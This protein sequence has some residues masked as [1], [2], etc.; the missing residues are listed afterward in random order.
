M[1]VLALLVS[2]SHTTRATE[3]SLSESDSELESLS[4][5]L[6]GSASQPE[7]VEWMREI[8]RTIHQHPEMG[9]EEQQTSQL[10]RSELDSLGIEYLWPVAKT[11][12][13]ASIGS[14]QKP[15]FALRADMDA[16][17]VQ[18]V[19]V[20]YFKGGQARN[21]IPESVELGGTYRSLSPEGLNYLQKRISEIIEMQA[22]V[23]QCTTE[24]DF[25]ED[26]PM[27]HTVMVNDRALYE[28]G[29][30]V[31]E[32]LFGKHNVETLPLTMG[33]EDFSFFSLR[34]PAAIFAIG[35]KNETLKSD[36]PLHSPYFFVD[37]EAFLVGAAFHAAMAIS[38]LEDH[39]TSCDG[40]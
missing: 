17:P 37:E 22:T 10:I 23:H 19:T 3:E 7:F 21:V 24:V 12:V 15:L 4:Q 25:H 27:P 16:L 2:H 40:F 1:L 29:K 34:M 6:L 36:A 14:G 13:I 26:V 35:I 38:Y 8:R 5:E 30:R 28:H 9:F 39:S 20:G 33:A 11:G 32:R 18:V 31:G